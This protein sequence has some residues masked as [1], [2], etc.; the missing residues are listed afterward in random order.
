MRQHFR[1]HCFP[2]SAWAGEKR[3]D[4]KPATTRV[5]ETPLFVDPGAIPEL[6]CQ[7]IKRSQRIWRKHEVVP[8]DV[9][10]DP[11]GEIA[12]RALA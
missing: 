12:R 7:F 1:R 9:R 11:L 6:A 2:R 4:A 8:A 10:F 3:A 5:A